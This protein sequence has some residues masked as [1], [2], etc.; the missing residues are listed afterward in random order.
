MYIF[1]LNGEKLPSMKELVKTNDHI[2]FHMCEPVSVT[3]H[4]HSPR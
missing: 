3:Q 1:K 2:V 4:K